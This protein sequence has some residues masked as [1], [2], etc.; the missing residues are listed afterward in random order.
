MEHLYL[1][2]SG[3][4]EG[5]TPEPGCFIG[6]FL[7]TS[8]PDHVA[9]VLR[10]LADRLVTAGVLPAGAEPKQLHV[11]DL[12]RYPEKMTVFRE[13]SVAA[14]DQLADL[15]LVS[16][17]WFGDADVLVGDAAD[18]RAF[19]RFLRMWTTLLRNLVGCAWWPGG[20]LHVHT[21]Q[22]SIPK[23]QVEGQDWTLMGAFS[24]SGTT[25]EGM[26]KVVGGEQLP[27][28]LRGLDTA[29][30]RGPFARRVTAADV[31]GIS[32]A[33]WRA[34][35]R[36]TTLAGLLLAD[37]AC[38]QIRDGGH[39]E[40]WPHAAVAYTPAW[41]RLEGLVDWCTRAPEA[42]GDLLDLAE[43][44]TSL[45]ADP[46]VADLARAWANSLVEA[47]LRGADRPLRSVAVGIARAEL[48]RKEARF[49]RTDRIFA[50]LPAPP[51]DADH[52]DE[53]VQ[54][55]IHA[56]HSGEAGGEKRDVLRH[57]LEGLRSTSLDAVLGHLESIAVLAVGYQDD[58]DFDEAIAVARPW[59][60]RGLSVAEL[61]PEARW[62]DLGRLASNLAQSLA[63]R[64]G[65]AD[66]EEGARLM[67]LAR[68]HL[69][70]PIDLSQW[71]CH[72]ANLAA[73][74][75]DTDLR[76]QAWVQLFGGPEADRGLD[77]VAGLRFAAGQPLHSLFAATVVTRTALVGR[78]AFAQRLRDRL[79]S[80]DLWFGLVA[81]VASA[82]DGHP[83]ERYLRH[84]AELAPTEAGA[85]QV[86]A[87]TERSVN[88]FGEPSASLVAPLQ[89]ACTYAAVA[90]ARLRLGDTATGQ[91]LGDRVLPTLMKRFEHNPWAAPTVLC[92][93]EG[94]ESGWLLDA[95]RALQGGVTSSSLTAFVSRF[96]YEWR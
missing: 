56:N 10:D 8:P 33:T 46:E 49:R 57:H 38:E 21:A 42:L 73:L 90:L 62:T 12:R 28:L 83:L 4:F 91:D 87:L 30:A 1:D 51:V 66:L 29:R 9:R 58:F 71:G 20:D 5:A 84:L 70:H 55:T 89:G 35:E 54:R 25:D 92:V 94:C 48:A 43:R 61:F 77:Y 19:N 76:D 40:R 93:E 45:D 16:C 17:R 31:G 3:S 6:G 23:V 86:T 27:Q 39:P 44:T 95:A 67:R 63:C 47:L 59:L 75:D 50:T 22:R 11:T 96:R 88:A 85:D 14:L 72:A 64:A 65:S 15:K 34:V 82:D 41:D 52:L 69:N 32:S 80:T 2:E 13:H 79:S 7:T 81:A 26:V 60:D 74:A 24:T 37:I 53:W 36:D 78:D 68:H 18:A